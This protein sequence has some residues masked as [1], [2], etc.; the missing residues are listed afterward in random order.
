VAHSRPE[1]LG[2]AVYTD[3]FARGGLF[4]DAPARQLLQ[5]LEE[6]PFFSV[7]RSPSL[8]QA[9][10]RVDRQDSRAALI[11]E[12]GPDGLA[13][14]RV[15]LDVT[16]LTIQQLAGGELQQILNE[17]VREAAAA[18]GPLP[19]EA[20]QPIPALDIQTNEIQQAGLFDATASPLIILIVLGVCLLTSVTALTSER[21]AGTYERLFS[22]PF[23]KGEVILSK[24]LARSLLA[25]LVSGVILLT[26]KLVFDIAMARPA[27][28]LL[29]AVLTG[30]NGVTFGLLISSVTRVE[31]ESVSV[32]I[33]GW[34]LFITLM[35]FMWP[36]ETMHPV[37]QRAALLT[38]YFHG[39]FAMKHINLL[40]WELRQVLPALA[41]LA[42]FIPLQL[43]LSSL[44]LKREL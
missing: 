37:F 32:G 12:E 18:S 13:R 36:L 19:P 15:I 26:L 6:S 31:L 8:G 38:P 22:L 27:L 17:R 39:V 9:L 42:G 24:A 44:L 28:A 23:K 4:E 3:S 30:I 35:G 43:L 5:D 25:A 40:G 7:T 33:T 20:L 29:V 14:A 10:E 1:N 34:F 11:L 2:I 41:W 16:D 21:T